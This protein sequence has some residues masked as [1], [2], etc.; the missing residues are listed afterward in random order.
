MQRSK[1]KIQTTFQYRKKFNDIDDEL[2][3]CSSLHT[4]N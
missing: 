1:L 2:N 3:L 4:D